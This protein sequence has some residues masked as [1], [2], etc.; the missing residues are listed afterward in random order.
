MLPEVSPRILAVSLSISV[1]TRSPLFPGLLYKG[2]L[3]SSLFHLLP[4]SHQV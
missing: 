2:L 1:I 4:V 3:N